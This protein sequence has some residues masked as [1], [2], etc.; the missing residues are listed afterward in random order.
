MA[1]SMPRR[2]PTD[3]LEEMHETAEQQRRYLDGRNPE[4]PGLARSDR[5]R[6]GGVGLITAD[7]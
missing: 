3:E 5:G 4:G 7:T 1:M 6:S 2:L